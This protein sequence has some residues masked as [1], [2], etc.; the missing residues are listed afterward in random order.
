MVGL[1]LF[2]FHMSDALACRAPWFGEPSVSLIIGVKY[3]G[4]IYFS[5]ALDDG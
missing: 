4:F 2:H 3:L 1:P 5:L